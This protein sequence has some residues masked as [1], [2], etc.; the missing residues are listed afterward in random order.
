M[1][2]AAIQSLSSEESALLKTVPAYITILI[3][4]ADAQLDSHEAGTGMKAVEY[5]IAHGDDLLKD[6]YQWVSGT[7]SD[8]LF[9]L[10]EQHKHQDSAEF[11]QDISEKL[12]STGAILGKLD[13][14]YAHHLLESWRGLARA[15][16]QASGGIHGKGHHVVDFEEHDWMG[17]NMISIPV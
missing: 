8:Q 13:K 3:G 4:G 15:V 14:K 9:S 11:I 6:Y 7:F 12:A 16:A 1:S 2:I 17:L 5:R 10:L